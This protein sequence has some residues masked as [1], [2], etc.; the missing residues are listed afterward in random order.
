MKFYFLSFM[1]DYF[2][3][4]C[5]PKNLHVIDIIFCFFILKDLYF[6]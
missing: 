4:D 6:L 3:F 2:D 1:N 5:R